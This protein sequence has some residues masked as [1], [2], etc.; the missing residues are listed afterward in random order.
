MI[1]ETVPGEKKNYPTSCLWHKHT[2]TWSKHKIVCH[3]R[4]Q[5]CRGKTSRTSASIWLRLALSNARHFLLDRHPHSQHDLQRVRRVRL[6]PV[7]EEA[8][9]CVPVSLAPLFF[10]TAFTFTMHSMPFCGCAFIRLSPVAKEVAGKGK[11]HAAILTDS[12]IHISQHVLLRMRL[13]R[14]SPV[15]EEAVHG[16]QVSLGGG[17]SH[18]RVR[19][20][21]DVLPLGELVLDSDRDLAQGIDSGCYAAKGG[22]QH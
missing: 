19:R 5:S 16:V 14:L 12:R 3:S 4:L 11:P 18:V 17:V 20:F 7:A 15:A 6:S 8:I 13:V 9:H 21:A 1:A 22:G 2:Q 10:L